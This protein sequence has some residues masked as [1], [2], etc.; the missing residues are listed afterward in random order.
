MHQYNLFNQ[1]NKELSYIINGKDANG[2][3]K[4]LIRSVGGLN[5]DSNTPKLALQFGDVAVGDIN[6]DGSNDF[7]YTGEDINGS[8]GSSCFLQHHVIPH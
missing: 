4:T 5:R 6:N 8:P 3:L 2:D 7:M 1:D